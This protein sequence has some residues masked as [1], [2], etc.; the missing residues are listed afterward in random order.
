MI[1]L[2]TNLTKNLSE[3]QNTKKIFL[4]DK[5]QYIYQ[6][7]IYHVSINNRYLKF[8][9]IKI[10]LQTFEL[11]KTLKCKLSKSYKNSFILN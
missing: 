1:Y 11:N 4:R 5:M 10:L 6:S 3:S 8:E 2:K 7:S 9:K